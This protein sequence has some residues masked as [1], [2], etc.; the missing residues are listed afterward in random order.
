[1]PDIKKRKRDFML[2]CMLMFLSIKGK[3]NFLQLE[4]YGNYRESTYRQ[5]FASG[6]DYVLFNEHLI[7]ETCGEERFIAFDP[8]Y[9]PKS[10]KK[11][12][13]LGTFWS[14][15]AGKAKKGIEIA[16]LA[17][18][19]VLNHS[20]FHLEAVQSPKVAEL[21]ERGKNLMSHYL[22]VIL[23]RKDV[24]FNMSSYLVADGYFGQT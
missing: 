11:T 23:E 12:Y 18:I 22:E 7:N 5:N 20:A 19:D 21:K 17:I 3:L 10:G 1:M 2:D 16:G 13:G 15:V 8:S 24:L 4:R 9:L 14:G 6:F